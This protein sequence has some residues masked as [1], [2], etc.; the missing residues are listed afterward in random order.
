MGAVI[1]AANYPLGSPIFFGPLLN[2]LVYVW[3]R[4]NPSSSVSFFG[5]VTCPSRWLPYVNIGLDLLQGGPG[6]AIQ[7]GT[8]LLRDM[9]TGYST[10]CCPHSAVV[11]VGA[12]V[13][14]AA[15]SPHP[16]S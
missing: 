1:L 11:E 12:A 13:A 4:A 15:T 3:A 2:A 7:S 6:L 9:S 10:R 16:D 14:V 8:G 5:M